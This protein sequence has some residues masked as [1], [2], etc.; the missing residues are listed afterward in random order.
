VDGIGGIAREDEGFAQAGAGHLLDAAIAEQD[1][2]GSGRRVLVAGVVE[3][4]V[5]VGPERDECG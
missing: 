3:P 4:E 5:G 2:A 1:N